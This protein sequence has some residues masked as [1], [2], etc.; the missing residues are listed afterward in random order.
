MFYNWFKKKETYRFL[1]EGKQEIRAVGRPF[2]TAKVLVLTFEI[3]QQVVHTTMMMMMAIIIIEGCWL[4]DYYHWLFELS[5]IVNLYCF[6]C[7]S[8]EPSGI[9]GIEFDGIHL[10]LVNIIIRRLK[11]ALV[12]TSIANFNI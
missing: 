9:K 12:F 2:E 1:H 11:V 5:Q 3:H 8:G 4:V 10:A 6:V 7:Q